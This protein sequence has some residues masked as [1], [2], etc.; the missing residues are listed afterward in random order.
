MISYITTVHKFPKEN[1]T[2]LM[3][4]KQHTTP[5]KQNILDAFTNLVKSCQAGDV[6]F[7]HFAGTYRLQS[8][9]QSVSQSASQSINQLCMLF[10]TVSRKNLLS[11]DCAYFLFE[12]Q[13]MD[14]KLKMLAVMKVRVEFYRIVIV[15]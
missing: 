14:P 9:S 1:I 12:L 4:D 8:V 7:C 10:R 15:Q 2:I 6:V 11:C 3:D 5:T 13:V